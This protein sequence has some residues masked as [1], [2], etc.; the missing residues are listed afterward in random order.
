[1]SD[2]EQQVTRPFAPAAFIYDDAHVRVNAVVTGPG[3]DEPPA[4]ISVAPISV[5]LSTADHHAIVTLYVTPGVA[6]ALRDGLAS[7]LAPR[8]VAS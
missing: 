1:M 7:V 5:Y 3:D 6:A 4:P 8:P 2:I